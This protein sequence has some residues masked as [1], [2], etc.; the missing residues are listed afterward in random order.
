MLHVVPW[1]ITFHL[2]DSMTRS[3]KSILRGQ[4]DLVQLSLAESPLFC[5]ISG[6]NIDANSSHFRESAK[7]IP[8]Y[9]I[10]NRISDIASTY[11]GYQLAH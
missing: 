8:L 5:R 9:P 1:L 6:S 7:I 10:Y 3:S 11:Y 2:L 4:F